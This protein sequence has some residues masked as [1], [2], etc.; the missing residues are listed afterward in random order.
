MALLDR[1]GEA[2]R[3]SKR[4][5]PLKKAGELRMALQRRLHLCR[6]R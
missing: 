5:L 6:D 2:N 4:L 3:H 1:H